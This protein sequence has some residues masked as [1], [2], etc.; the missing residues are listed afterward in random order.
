LLIQHPA[1]LLSASELPHAYSQSLSS[2]YNGDGVDPNRSGLNNSVG[3][4]KDLRKLSYK[5]LRDNYSPS[6]AWLG[7]RIW[8]R[9]ES[10]LLKRIFTR[11][12]SP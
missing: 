9:A 6:C 4:L 11:V 8:T 10:F 12:T 2:A 1:D 5:Y 7:S 3:E